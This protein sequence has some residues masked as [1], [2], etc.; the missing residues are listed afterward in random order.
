[1]SIN[2]LNPGFI[3]YF[4]PPPLPMYYPNQPIYGYGIILL[5]EEEMYYPN[6]TSPPSS[7]KVRRLNPRSLYRY[8]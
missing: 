5:S 1:M 6:H 8:T 4:Y 3:P 7:P 2:F